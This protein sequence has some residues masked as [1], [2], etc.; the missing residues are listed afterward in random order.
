VNES[1]SPARSPAR[2]PNVVA[3]GASAGGLEPLKAFFRAMPENPQLAFVVITH[4]PADHVSHL[5]ALL[6]RAGVLR[7]PGSRSSAGACT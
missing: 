7:A 6:D 3:I 2:L 1:D 5:P 4:L